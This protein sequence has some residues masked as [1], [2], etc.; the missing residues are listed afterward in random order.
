M[1]LRSFIGE[2]S[3]S[4]VI[5]G[6]RGSGASGLFAV[7]GFNRSVQ[8]RSWRLTNNGK[9]G[10]GSPSSGGGGDEPKPAVVEREIARLRCGD[11]EKVHHTNT[12]ET[13]GRRY[14][15][16][17]T[18]RNFSHC[19]FDFVREGRTSDRIDFGYARK[20]PSKYALFSFTEGACGGGCPEQETNRNSV[21]LCPHI[22][23]FEIH[24]FLP[25][26]FFKVTEQKTRSY[27]FASAS[28]VR[29]LLFLVVN[30][31][32]RSKRWRFPPQANFYS[33][34]IRRAERQRYGPSN[35]ALVSFG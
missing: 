16:P 9:T 26:F 28:S 30:G 13:R 24:V 7:L 33:L 23:L 27:V 34:V 22:F 11:H 3:G 8:I 17:L 5:D 2:S 29:L 18:I 10:S 25:T 19:L 6:P 4:K 35:P 21:D 1:M 14:R 15:R 20:R 31:G 12:E 32:G